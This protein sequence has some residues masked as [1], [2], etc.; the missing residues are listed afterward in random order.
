MKTCAQILNNQS[1]PHA[2][3]S[4]QRWSVLDD[5]TILCSFDQPLLDTAKELNRSYYG[6][7]NRRT[8]VRRNKSL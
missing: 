2:K 6:T 1:V 5:V 7:A 4:N 3:K 8:T